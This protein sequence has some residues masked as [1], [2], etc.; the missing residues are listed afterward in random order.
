MAR[1][2]T[3]KND[4]TNPSTVKRNEELSNEIHSMISSMELSLYGTTNDSDIDNLI[5]KFN[6]VMTDELD[7]INRHTNKD[8]TSFITMLL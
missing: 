3:S 8:M 2:R 1:Q 5:N 7:G 4:L 6:S